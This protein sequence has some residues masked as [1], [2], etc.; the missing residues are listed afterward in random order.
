MAE[1]A[2][3]HAPSSAPS[4]TCCTRVKAG[5][6]ADQLSVPASD[7]KEAPHLIMPRHEKQKHR[8]PTAG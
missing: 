5:V 2:R 1:L 7:S 8:V 4:A 6:S 3:E